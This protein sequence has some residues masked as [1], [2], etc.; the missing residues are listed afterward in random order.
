M[1]PKVAEAFDTLLSLNEV[2]RLVFIDRLLDSVGPSDEVMDDVEARAADPSAK[3]YSWDEVQ[4]EANAIL[5][6]VRRAPDPAP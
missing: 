1:S 3:T 4:A 5:G 6:E 2:D